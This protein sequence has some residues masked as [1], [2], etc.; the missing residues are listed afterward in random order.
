MRILVVGAG[1]IGGYF[2][3]RLAA[4]GRDVTFL[5]RPKRAEQLADGLFV[6]SPKGNVKIVAPKLVTEATRSP[7]GIP[8]LAAQSGE[9]FDLILLSCKSYDL[10]SAMDSL[11]RGVGTATMILPL[12]NGVSHIDTLK[13]R[14]GAGAVLGGQCQ[15]SSTL[16]EQGHVV[17]LND[18]HTLGFGE[19]DGS[20]STRVE[21]VNESFSGANF[22]A[23]LSLHILHDMWEKWMFI[24]TMGGITCLMRAAVGD[25]ETAGGTSIALELFEECSA[26]AGKNGH[27]PR[28]VI[29]ERIRKML[30][31]PGST[32]TASMLRDVEGHRK[33]EH[34][35]VLGD[36]LARA[37]GT[38][39][40][41]LEI[42]LANLRA[43]EARRSSPLGI[44]SLAA[45]SREG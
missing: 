34:E 4:I 5:V 6:R 44:P 12:L 45:R 31:T 28:P 23:Q 13:K 35:H 24:A 32:L 27:A 36:L 7:L 42:C 22:E 26:I 10:D 37:Q 20:P 39:A 1:A 41:I 38:R 16:D 30:T 43:Y 11:A 40:P 3:A 19:L 18:M 15:I 29:G 14:F 17:H 33:T 25:I 2:G 9:P 21:A 8:S